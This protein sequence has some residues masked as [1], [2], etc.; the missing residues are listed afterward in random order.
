MAG[1]NRDDV[2]R[3]RASQQHDISKNIEDLVAYE[4]VAEPQ[5]FVARMVSFRIS[6]AFRGCRF[7]Q[8]VVDEVLNFLIKRE[9]ARGRNLRLKRVRLDGETQELRVQSRL[10]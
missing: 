10:P 6:T 9:R 5:G 2:R 3:Q 4:F 7:D 1:P 8:A